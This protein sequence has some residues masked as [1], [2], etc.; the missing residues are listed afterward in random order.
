MIM[1]SRVDAKLPHKKGNGRNE[2]SDGAEMGPCAMWGLCDNI[3]IED[4][5]SVR[6]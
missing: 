5:S 3:L 4:A 2:V 1:N 6:A